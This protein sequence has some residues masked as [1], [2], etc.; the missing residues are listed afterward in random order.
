MVKRSTAR[1]RMPAQ[2]HGDRNAQRR[3][4][5]I[6]DD[7]VP[8][9]LAA[10]LRDYTI[11]TPDKHDF[12][13]VEAFTL[14]GDP[15]HYRVD[16]AQSYASG[17]AEF[18]G[19]VDGFFL[20]FRD[21]TIIGR[22][23]MSVSAPNMLRVRIA[24]DSDGEYAPAGGDVLDIQGASA[25]IIIEPPGAP[26]AEAVLTGHN[27]AVHVYIHRDALAQLYAGGEHELP[28]VVQAFLAGDLRQTFARQ[29]PLGAGMMR[30]LE[31]IQ[32]CTL[33]GRS[34]RLFIQ[35]TMVNILCQAFD[36]M[37]QEDGFGS[38]EAS[39]LTTR[40]VFRAQR[41][42]AENF[43]T[44]PSLD[45]LAHEVGLSR[46]CLCV[47]FRQIFGQSVF[48]YIVELRMQQALTLMKERNTSITQIAYAVGYGHLSSFTVAV[49][50]RFG[51]TP[52]ELRRRHCHS[53]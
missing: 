41:L 30:C 23:A 3:F 27:R 21:S 28:A 43:V 48:D 5:V 42:L 44:P 33:E 29:L 32:T 40:G 47:G 9:V 16:Y 46:T 49:Q 11:S 15:C 12:S 2:L 1:P 22:T 45:D 26:P 10:G 38:V 36:T 35:A 18:C 7:C 52:S 51:T 17:H 34:R 53:V 6:S 37:A 8:V 25:T 14:L 20:F 13:G 19:V 50:R 24:S 31:D 4:E 39:V